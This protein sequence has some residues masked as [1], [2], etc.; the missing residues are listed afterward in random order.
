MKTG[1]IY[2]LKS[3]LTGRICYVGQTRGCVYVRYKGHVR[4]KT[5]ASKTIRFFGEE[6]F[7]V[8]VIEQVPEDKLNAAEAYW[9]VKFNTLAPGG[10]NCTEGG[11]ASRRS[12]ATKV[13]MSVARKAVWAKEGFREKTSAALAASWT[14]ERRAARSEQVKELMS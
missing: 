2:G 12:A 8:V 3:E 9:I 4:G 7:S 11:G 14:E 6:D 5:L 1:V 10:L 13:R